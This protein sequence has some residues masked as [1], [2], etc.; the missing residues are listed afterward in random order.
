MVRSR[1]FLGAERTTFYVA[2]FLSARLESM[3][4]ASL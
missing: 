1:G 3:L 2:T 4:H